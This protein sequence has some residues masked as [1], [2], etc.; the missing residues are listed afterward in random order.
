MSR[1]STHKPILTKKTNK[2]RI[3]PLQQF[4]ISP[5]AVEFG[6]TIGVDTEDLFQLFDIECG[7]HSG[8][9]KCC[10]LFFVK[11]W[12]PLTFCGLMPL[13]NSY[14]AARMTL[15]PSAQYIMCPACLL[16]RNVVEIKPCDCKKRIPALCRAARR[17]RRAKLKAEP[18]RN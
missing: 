2:K 15:G 11:L 18:S 6:R 3:S 4:R 1:L 13:V 16:A 17:K 7:L 14:M 5:E 12:R 8:I 9:P 10:I